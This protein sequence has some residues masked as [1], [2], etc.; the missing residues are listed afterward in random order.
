MQ[1]RGAAPDPQQPPGLSA[2]TPLLTS[3][4]TRMGPS[5]P[6]LRGS[7]VSAS[8][9]PQHRGWG[10]PRPPRSAVPATAVPVPL[11]ARPLLSLKPGPRLL[12]TQALCRQPQLHPWPEGTRGCPPGPQSS[13][14]GL[15]RRTPLT[16]PQGGLES[17]PQLPAGQG[18]PGSSS[19]GRRQRQRGQRRPPTG[20]RRSQL[21]ES[22][23]HTHR[24]GTA[25]SGP[26]GTP[27]GRA[28]SVR[29]SNA[30]LDS[31]NLRSE[32]CAPRYPRNQAKMRV[33]KPMKS[34]KRAPD[35]RVC[36]PRGAGVVRTSVSAR[37][38]P[39]GATTVTAPR[40]R[41]PPHHR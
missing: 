39:A 12:H 28:G 24:P 11:G 40:P 2:D 18:R 21:W 27:A 19:P 1:T 23:P 31:E 4:C 32:H 35:C 25:T 15:Q 7:W 26:A 3:L 29:T 37:G 33:F 41:P 16:V 8:Q 17:K 38:E 22:P 36:E 5:P 30:F 20:Q 14:D 13:S 6:T 34:G 10:A 9:T